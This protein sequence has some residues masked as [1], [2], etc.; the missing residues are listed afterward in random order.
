MTILKAEGYLFM[1]ISATPR[2][3]LRKCSISGIDYQPTRLITSS[4]FCPK[5]SM[6]SFSRF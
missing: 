4:L 6:A 5:I 2:A 1:N 3:A